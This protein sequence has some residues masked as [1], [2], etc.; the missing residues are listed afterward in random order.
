[1]NLQVTL[2]GGSPQLESKDDLRKYFRRAEKQWREDLG[3]D[4]LLKTEK[5]LSQNLI[6][7]L[8]NKQGFWCAYQALGDEAPVKSVFSSH[9]KLTWVFPKV[10]GQELTF[11][12]PTNLDD[13]TVGSY[14]IAEPDMKAQQIGCEQI[15]GFLIPGQAFDNK[16]GRLGRG[17]SYYDRALQHF[18]GL[19][20]GVCF[21]PRLSEKPLPRE[22]WDIGMDYVITEKEVID[23]RAQ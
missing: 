15:Q 9:L 21:S 18:N 14:G 22:A 3:Q 17:K 1:M 12:I 11:W 5:V 10:S 13:F 20:V 16:G 4:T 19:K 8:N 2:E 6:E 7:F 23:C